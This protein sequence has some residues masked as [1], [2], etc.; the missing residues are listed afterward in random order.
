MPYPS[1]P[2]LA[3]AQG[4]GVAAGQSTNVNVDTFAFVMQGVIH[5]PSSGGIIQ[6]D[7][8]LSSPMCG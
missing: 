8:C 6:H 7:S 5:S 1:Y 4:A 3:D 2:F